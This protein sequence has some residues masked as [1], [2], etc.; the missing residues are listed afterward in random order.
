MSLFFRFVKNQRLLRVTRIL[1]F[2]TIWHRLESRIQGMFVSEGSSLAGQIIGMIFGI[3]LVS[4]LTGCIWYAI[5]KHSRRDTGVSWLDTVESTPDG[6]VAFSDFSP[7]YQYTTAYHWCIVQ[8]FTGSVQINARNTSERVFNILCNIFGTFFC[9]VITSW[10]AA[11]LVRH[12]SQKFDFDVVMKSVRRYLR[13]HDVNPSVTVRVE[14][15]LGLRLRARTRCIEDDIPAFQLLSKSL[16]TEMRQDI[17]SKTL[18]DFQIIYLLHQYD[19]VAFI[20]NL[21]WLARYH[22]LGVGDELF[23]AHQSTLDTYILTHGALVYHRVEEDELKI[24]NWQ[25]NGIFKNLHTSIQC[26][27]STG[28]N[29]QLHVHAIPGTWLSEAAMFMEWVTQGACEAVAVSELISIT[30]DMLESAAKRNNQRHI[31]QAYQLSYANLAR[32]VASSCLNDIDPPVSH[33]LVILTLE[34]GARMAA[35]EPVLAKMR[36]QQNKAWLKTNLR[37]GATELEVEVQEGECALIFNSEG[38]PARV[39]FIVCLRVVRDDGLMLAQV[40]KL[41][42]WCLVPKMQMIAT[43][44]KD[45]ENAAHAAQRLI[46]SKLVAFGEARELGTPRQSEK[47]QIVKSYG[48]ETRFL[49][50]VFTVALDPSSSG[51]ELWPSA[52]DA[53][54]QSSRSPRLSSIGSIGRESPPVGPSL[55]LNSG[56]PAMPLTGLPSELHVVHQNGEGIAYAWILPETFD[57]MHDNELFEKTIASWVQTMQFSLAKREECRSRSRARSLFR[58]PGKSG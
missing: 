34:Q 29:A 39:A 57:K 27:E 48:L 6:E 19:S 56:G 17:L 53:S 8:M 37:N 11:L 23:P 15:Q 43:K 30:R 16:K 4:H 33:P 20:R 13:E 7:L 45:G 50:T 32:S 38:N 1:R 10:L 24:V 58:S 55:T 54:P 40:A 26:N 31:I 18:L 49:Q 3:L 9:A 42:D 14:Q 47:V 52:A 22:S 5:G 28:Y 25:S 41:N 12:Q 51:P 36:D 44:V 21:C 46:L 35:A 2:S